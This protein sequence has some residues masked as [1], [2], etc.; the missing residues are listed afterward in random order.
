MAQVITTKYVGPTNARGSRVIVNSWQGRKTYGWDSALNSEENHALAAA[1]FVFQLNKDREENEL[2]FCKWDII[3]GGGM[4]DGCGYGFVIDLVRAPRLQ[5]L[6]EME[7][8]NP[9]V[10]ANPK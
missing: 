2:D 1:H 9:L 3:S 6:D 4:P 7:A 8:E 5:T 10:F